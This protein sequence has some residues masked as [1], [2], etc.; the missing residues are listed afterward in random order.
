M[1][2]K[3]ESILP[4]NLEEQGKQAVAEKTDVYCSGLAQNAWESAPESERESLNKEFNAMAEAAFAGLNDETEQRVYRTMLSLWQDSKL[5]S[6]KRS[7]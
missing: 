6:L 2:V 7:V 4:D 1:S 5:L 3:Q